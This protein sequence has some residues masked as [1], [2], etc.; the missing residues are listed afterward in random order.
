MA[1]I[2]RL[3][4][5]SGVPFLRVTDIQSGSWKPTYSDGGHKE[6]CHLFPYTGDVL[7]NIIGINKVSIGK[8]SASLSVV[9]IGSLIKIEPAY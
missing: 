3:L 6:L 2:L 5:E 4:C 8:G 1:L 7:K 9:F